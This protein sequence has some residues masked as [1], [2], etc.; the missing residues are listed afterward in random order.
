MKMRKIFEDI[1]YDRRHDPAT[2]P[3][4]EA[5]RI[6]SL[7]YG[8]G[9]KL[10]NMLFDRGLMLRYG[11]PC[12]VISIGNITVGGTGKTPVAIMTA[13]LLVSADYRVAVVSRG[14]GRVSRGIQF[15]SDASGILV[16]PDEAGD[17][18]HLIASSL[19]GIPVV[20]GDDRAEAARAAFQRFEPD[21][22]LLDDAFQHRRLHR[23]FDI[24]ALDA[25]N[26]F[27]SGLLL[28]R[29]IL[30]E[31]PRAL[32]R[33][34]AVIVTR[35]SDDNQFAAAEK[36]VHVYNSGVA[37]FQSRHVPVSL[38]LPFSAEKLELSI[39]AGKKV[40]ALSN[41]GSP[42]SFYRTLE[43]LGAKIV[44]KRSMRDHHRYRTGELEKIIEEV[45][46]SGA[47]VFIMT[48]KD[49]RN[50]PEDYRP[51]GKIPEYVLD[52]EA[53]LEGDEEKY[54][55]LIVGNIS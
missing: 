31:S 52:I 34:Q 11:L 16:S 3:L 45:L 50:L 23:D 21:F 13:R 19:P 22:I 53:V 49:E 51:S 5:L 20:V 38:R 7:L 24:V 35:C 30:R 4:R 42:D 37:V 27:G 25:E 26:P 40:A 48:A 1:L 54:L 32:S 44:F 29:G 2:L 14:Y 43:S 12:R 41:I 33:A 36:S 8:A 47:E 28:P 6:S 17:E 55:K 10:R 18:P 9:S 15:V 39:I 46:R